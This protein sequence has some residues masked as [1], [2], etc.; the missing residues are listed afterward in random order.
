MTAPQRP[1]FT[2]REF[3]GATLGA[4]FA[5]AVQ[6]V[7]AQ[8]RIVTPE[9]GLATGE[10]LIPTADRA[11]PAYWARPE[12]QGPWPT[13]LVVSEI[14]AVHE[15]IRDICRRLAHQGYLA[16]APELFVRQGD[17]RQLGSIPQI[18]GDIIAR[19]P[20]EQVQSDLDATAAWAPQQGGDPERLGITGFC[21]GGRQVW[22]YA[23]RNPKLK[24][25]VAWYGRLE[26]APSPLTPT[27]PRQV[28]DRLQAPVLGLYGGADPSI[29]PD[30]VAAMEAAL[31]AS[32]NPASRASHI[33]VYPDAPH[34]FHADYR[35]SYRPQAAMDGWQRM[36]AW[37]R[38]QGL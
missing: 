26:G 34:A 9:V 13:L 21:W 4:G 10:S 14:F 19:V 5:L 28:A 12:G 11:I 17:P 37:F 7:C 29:P 35:P 23:A 38:A 24:A 22:L 25:G 30:T 8:T 31:G 6:P 32:S 3:L 18:M 33:E 27:Y 36:L 16:V 15:Y 1:D 20:D 2:R